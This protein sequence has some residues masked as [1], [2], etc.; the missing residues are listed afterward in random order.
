MPEAPAVSIVDFS[1]AASSFSSP[2]PTS[3]RPRPLG[4]PR[5]A[6]VNA[7]A[8]ASSEPLP[9][10]EEGDEDAGARI[11]D[12]LRGM[13]DQA[14]K[15]RFK[16]LQDGLNKFPGVLPDGGK[17]YRRSL[18]A[19]RGELDRRTRLASDSA[20]LRPRPRP[21]RPQGRLG[22]P[23]GNRG[24][25]MIQS[26]CAEPSGL[27]S[28]CNE[29]HGVTKS[30][31]LSAF[32]V[33]D[34]AGIDVEITSICPGKTKTP[35]ENKGK[36]YAVSESCKTNAQPTPPK[37]LCIDN[38]IDVENMSSDDDFKDNGD[39]R[40]R[41]NA[42]TPSRKRKG[43]DSVNF[44]MRLRPRKA[45]EVVLLDADAHHSE[46]AEKPTTKRDAM[47]I[48][49]P[50][51]EHSNSIELSHDDIKCLEPESL[52]SSTI[53]NFYI[54]YLQGPM[55]SISTQRGKY[56]IFNTYFFKKLE[57]L[58]SKVDKPSYFLNLR[59]W[60]KGI[61]IFQ[62]PY[63]LF[64]VH[65]DTHWSLVIICMPAKED[66][67]GPIIL[68]LDSLKFHNSRLIFSVVERF[69][70]Q[71]WNYL[72]ENGSL[73]EC[74][75]RE[76]VWKKLPHKIEKKPIARFIEEA[77]E[78]L[79][80]KDL[81]MFGKTWF[82]PEEASALRKK[83]KTLLHQ[84]FEEADPSNDSTSEQ[85]ACQLLL[86]AKPANNVME[87]ATSEH[88]LEV[89][90]AEVIPTSEHLLEVGS[91]EMTPMS[92]HPLEVGSAEMSPT[93][94][95]PLVCS[96]GEMA[97]AQEHPLVGSSAEMEPTQEHP[98]V[99]NSAEMEP[100]QEYP[101]VGSSAEMAPTQEHTLVGSSAEMAPTQEHPLV[102][103]SAEMEPT[104][105]HPTVGSSAEMEQTQGHPMVGS[106]AEI[107]SQKPLEGTSTRPTSFEHPLECS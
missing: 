36:S 37:V 55:S 43:D 8:T 11:D 18:R 7:M 31:F 25:R 105:E 40:T 77:P 45:Q 82:Q 49:Y 29:N 30:D 48:Y 22:E 52:L 80:K 78:R 27:S 5:R 88:P 81:S 4:E 69:L 100:K 23:D 103:S 71:E 68:H 85:T 39:I 24:E 86:E 42:S 92:E 9:S 98:L 73:A 16:R 67:S 58:K 1:S 62:K 32:E 35:V 20:S 46:S 66:Q 70:K 104:Q 102:G 75:I 2:T 57:A 10:G 83:M 54:M 65:A 95:H 14:L 60:W 91:V 19:V 50:S 101:L 56:H 28:K 64:P 87:L 41:E 59:R 97:P 76:T 12:D 51:S 106:S 79:H 89:S 90:S 53:M 96:S 17:K 74:P 34:E 47:K 72:K 13:S 99:G 93:Q 44:S 15:E 3:P 38:S 33:D 94:E 61:D 26:S 107:T 63:I 6:A 21:P 84:L